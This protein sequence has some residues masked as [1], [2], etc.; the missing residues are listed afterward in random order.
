MDVE[1]TREI[2]IIW[3]GVGAVLGVCSIFSA[4]MVRQT[5][6][7]LI[8]AVCAAVTLVWPLLFVA[9]C[10]SL[11]GWLVYKAGEMFSK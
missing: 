2:A 1:L 8:A 4:G 10:V 7:N 6:V 3:L 11:I 5:N 9:G